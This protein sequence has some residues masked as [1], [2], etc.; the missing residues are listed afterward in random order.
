MKR[1]IAIVIATSLLAAQAAIAEPATATA[2]EASKTTSKKETIVV[3]GKLGTIKEERVKSVQ[4][5]LS[6]IPAGGGAS[7]DLIDISDT[8]ANGV[9]EHIES[10]EVSIP[11]WTLFSW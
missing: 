6:F 5:T 11:S 4:S 3:E 8:G 2:K 9:N 7:Y 1:V 10:E